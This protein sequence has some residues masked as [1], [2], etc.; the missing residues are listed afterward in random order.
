MRTAVIILVSLVLLSCE[1]EEPIK[2]EVFNEWMTESLN[3][4][5]LIQF[6]TYFVGDGFTGSRFSKN[7]PSEDIVIFY[8]CIGKWMECV[9]DIIRSP[10]PESVTILPFSA[11]CSFIE[12]KNKDYYFTNDS[13][14]MGIFYQTDIF[15]IDNKDIYMVIGQLYWNESNHY[16]S[17]TRFSYNIAK[18]DS[19]RMIVKT[20]KRK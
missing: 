15:K 10:Y 16:V 18:Q 12:L 1:K 5:Y 6:P 9:G 4:N 8:E 17:L 11:A 20:I 7:N 19:F 2:N 13:T 14:L 3:P